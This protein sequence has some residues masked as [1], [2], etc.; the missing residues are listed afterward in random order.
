MKRNDIE[1]GLALL[2]ALVVLVGV[3]SAA[4]S[5][6]A[7]EPPK[8]ETTATAIHEAG[9]ATLAPAR[10]ANNRS[11]AEAARAIALENLEALDIELTDRTS[12]LIA[13]N[14]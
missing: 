7:A 9:E 8:I 10:Q 14:E 6:F 13:G 1:N 5:A 2:G 12:T 11:A 3:T 4:S